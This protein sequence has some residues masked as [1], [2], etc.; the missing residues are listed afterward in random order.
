MGKKVIKEVW[1]SQLL[2]CLP[3]VV[4][5]T[6]QRS[7]LMAI[8]SQEFLGQFLSQEYYLGGLN[9]SLHISRSR[10][11]VAEKNTFGTCCLI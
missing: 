10:V 1:E 8:M 3:E 7:K 4:N 6:T 5:E 2:P 9:P 11:L